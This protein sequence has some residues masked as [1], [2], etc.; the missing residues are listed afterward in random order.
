MNETQRPIDKDLETTI[1]ALVAQK[2]REF[3]ERRRLL[4]NGPPTPRPDDSVTPDSSQ[5]VPE[6][7]PLG[8]KQSQAPLIL[9]S[10]DDA[11]RMGLEVLTTEA[12]TNPNPNRVLG[13]SPLLSYM[14]QDPNFATSPAA[15]RLERKK[16]S[17]LEKAQA[18][19]V[20]REITRVADR[21][22]RWDNEVKEDSTVAAT[23][24]QALQRLVNKLKKQVNFWREKFRQEARIRASVFEL[25]HKLDQERK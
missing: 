8:P 22:R 24:S 4:L 3:V 21:M 23:T 13:V 6:H 10:E 15:A 19:K 1:E 7:K 25:R 12:I 9:P 20:E 16:L 11:F 5:S 14:V 18:A 2:D 17:P